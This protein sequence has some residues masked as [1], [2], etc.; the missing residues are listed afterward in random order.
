[1]DEMIFA[2]LI[3]FMIFVAPIW[4]VMHYRTAAK[5]NVGLSNDEQ[6]SLQELME[7]ADGLEERIEILESILDQETPDWRA[8][9][10]Q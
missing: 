2:P 8:K 7:V 5:K 4:V 1:M 3:L 9:Y 6:Q 10:E